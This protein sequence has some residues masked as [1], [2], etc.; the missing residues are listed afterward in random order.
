MSCSNSLSKRWLVRRSVSILLVLACMVSRVP[1]G[2]RL[3]MST[4]WSCI[5]VG[6]AWLLLVFRVDTISHREVNFIS[7]GTIVPIDGA[8]L[9]M[10]FKPKLGWS[11]LEL[12]G[13]SANSGCLA[14]MQKQEAKR[15]G[16]DR[17]LPLR[18]LSQF[19]SVEEK[20]NCLGNEFLCVPITPQIIP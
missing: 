6:L 15:I 3:S 16:G 12:L 18:C 1:P 8:K 20:I 5:H 4:C 7:E 17:P 19:F 11:L 14:P 13:R 9:M 2:G 10:V